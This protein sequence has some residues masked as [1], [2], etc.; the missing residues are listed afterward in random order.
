MTVHQLYKALEVRITLALEE[1]KKRPTP[2]QVRVLD[3]QEARGFLRIS[4]RL[5]PNE[6]TNPE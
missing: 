4:R 6:L 2:R 3:L 1:E 5:L